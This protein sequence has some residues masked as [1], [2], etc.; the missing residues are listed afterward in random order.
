MYAHVCVCVCVCVYVGVCG[1]VFPCYNLCMSDKVC[2]LFPG[3]LEKKNEHTHTHTHTYT[4]TPAH[5]HP[6]IPSHACFWTQ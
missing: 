4:H 5:T 1:Y 2:M 6:N 3:C